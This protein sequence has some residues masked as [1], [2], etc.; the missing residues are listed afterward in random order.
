MEKKEMSI[1]YADTKD[2]T[3]KDLQELFQSAG[4]LSANYPE[5]LKKAFD[6]SETVYTAW[7]S[8][9]LK[10]FRHCGMRRIHVRY[11]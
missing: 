4:W 10:Y 7:D 5:R 1:I 2:Y 3:V 11:M 6:N 8:R 9:N